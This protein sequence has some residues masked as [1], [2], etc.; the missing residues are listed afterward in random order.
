VIEKA[1]LVER[2]DG[3]DQRLGVDITGVTR[4]EKPESS[5]LQCLILMRLS[6]VQAM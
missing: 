5:L 6:L 2:R 1:E 3:V 4:Q